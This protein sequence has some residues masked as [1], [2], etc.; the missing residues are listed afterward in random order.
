M[1]KNLHV[2]IAMIVAP[3][4]AVLAWFAVDYFVAERPQA[5]KEGGAYELIG[6]PNCRYASGQCDLENA[7]AELTIRPLER[8]GGS[9]SL[10]LTSS[11]ALQRAAMG[12][13]TAGTAGTPLSMT[14]VDGAMTRW[15]VR[16]PY[17]ENEATLRVAVTAQGAT[18]YAEVPVI[19]LNEADQ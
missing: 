16:L 7:D 13:A 4:L 12:F 15:L 11:F 14:A 6:K 8:A 5:A 1:F 19:F 3:I 17:P 2:A 10:E 9:I 18:L